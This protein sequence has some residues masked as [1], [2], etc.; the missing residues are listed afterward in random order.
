MLEKCTG[1]SQGCDSLQAFTVVSSF[2]KA[3][4]GWGSV[5]NFLPLHK[6]V[7]HNRFKVR[8]QFQYSYYG[9]IA[10]LLST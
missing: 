9:V 10:W 6:V 1:G 2:V 4:D 7:Q 3:T 8:L 5:I